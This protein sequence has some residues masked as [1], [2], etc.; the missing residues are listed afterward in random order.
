LLLSTILLSTRTSSPSIYRPQLRNT[1]RGRPDRRC[2]ITMRF[3]GPLVF[4]TAAVAQS[5][6]RSNNSSSKVTEIPN[7]LCNSSISDA[8]ASGIITHGHRDLYNT[9]DRLGAPDHSWAITVTG[10]NGVELERRFWYDTAGQNYADDVGID[11]DVCA[12]HNFHLPLNAHR[13]GRDDPGNCSTVFSQRC[14]D[15]VA[16]MASQ[17]ALKWTTYSSPPPYENLTAGVLPSICTYIE[18]D[19]Q[20]TIKKECGP[21]MQADSGVT[22]T[23]DNSLGEKLLSCSISCLRQLMICCCSIDGL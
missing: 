15:S 10:G 5:S 8:N 18:K 2:Y 23:F 13:L 9:G 7:R 14:I 1:F 17:S 11:T 3:A 4:A 19:L 12:F 21:Q 6:D 16:S 22:A 20:E